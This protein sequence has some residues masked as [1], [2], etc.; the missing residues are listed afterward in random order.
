MSV[1]AGEVAV[2]GTNT[3]CGR[4]GEV[5]EMIGF[6][7]APNESASRNGVCDALAN[8]AMEDRASGVLRLEM[9]LQIKRFENI[10]RKADREV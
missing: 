10:I 7:D 4:E 9:I 2:R 5:R 3:E 1:F 6:R 8:E